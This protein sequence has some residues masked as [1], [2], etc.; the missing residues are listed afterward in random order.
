ML[1]FK[2]ILSISMVA[3]FIINY[4]NDKLFS[5][6]T[7]G[8]L[9]NLATSVLGV[10]I[11]V[12]A[13]RNIYSNNLVFFFFSEIQYH[14]VIDEIVYNTTRIEDC[15]STKVFVANQNLNES[16]LDDATKKSYTNAAL[17]TFKRDIS[18]RYRGIASA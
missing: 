14:A 11:K 3:L 10:V 2:S 16:D 7:R 1:I 18:I 13:I 8:I 6:L 5:D 12:V 17:A 15:V 9:V 4:L